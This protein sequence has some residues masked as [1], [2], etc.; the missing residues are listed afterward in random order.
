M[1]V[2]YWRPFL[3]NNSVL[4]PWLK[5]SARFADLIIASSAFIYEEMK[6]IFPKNKIIVI[7]HV[8]QADEANKLKKV[9][10]AQYPVKTIGF[11]GSL[12]PAKGVVDLIDAFKIVAKTY[13]NL[14]LL[15]AGSG[16]QADRLNQKIKEY[17]LGKQVFLLGKQPKIDFL[18][19][20]DLVVVPSHFDSTPYVLQES[21]FAK[22]MM[23]ATKTGG[24]PALFN[25]Q[26]DQWLVKPNNPTDLANKILQ[27]LRLDRKQMAGIINENFKAI[28]EFTDYRKM[29]H[30]VEK[31]FKEVVDKV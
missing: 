4:M 31:S 13:P 3:V 10:P 2:L 9:L 11:I 14:K 30:E 17:N 5:F 15:Y 26:T 16:D 25:N 28:S 20:V 6:E 12:S 22:R 29:I 1:D 21:M 27:A 19:K 7:R 18:T 23:V 24:I 8:L